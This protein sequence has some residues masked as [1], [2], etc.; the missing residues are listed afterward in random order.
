MD[1]VACACETAR[2]LFGIYPDISIAMS[3]SVLCAALRSRSN[4][5]IFGSVAVLN[6][7]CVALKGI[8]ARW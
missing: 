8:Q 5:N 7:R 4:L 6:G 1:D 2:R 3:R